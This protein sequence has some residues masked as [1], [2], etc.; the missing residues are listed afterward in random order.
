MESQI[1]FVDNVP[2]DTKPFYSVTFRTIQDAE[3]VMI[4]TTNFYELAMAHPNPQ[5]VQ[6]SQ[7][8]FNLMF[9]RAE[10]RECCVV[11]GDE[12][13]LN[14]DK[15][16]DGIATKDLTATLYTLLCKYM[17]V[18]ADL[19]AP[20]GEEGDDPS[21]EKDE[22]AVGA[23]VV[24]GSQDDYRDEKAPG[25]RY[26][27][28]TTALT[29]LMR[30]RKGS[31]RASTTTVDERRERHN[32]YIGQ[33]MSLPSVHTIIKEELAE[34]KVD[35]PELL[36]TLTNICTLPAPY[37]EILVRLLGL[38]GM[39]GLDGGPPHVSE[40]GYLVVD[41]A[42]KNAYN[43]DMLNVKMDDLPTEKF[44]HMIR[45]P[46][47]V[48]NVVKHASIASNEADHP[49][50][51]NYPDPNGL[52][53]DL[54]CMRRGNVVTASKSNIFYNV[55]AQQEAFN[56]LYHDATHL[57]KDQVPQ[58]DLE[59]IM[60]KNIF[61]NL[62]VDPDSI[63]ARYTVAPVMD[64]LYSNTANH[65]YA[66]YKFHSQRYDKVT[67]DPEA[68]KEIHSA[69]TSVPPQAIGGDRAST[70]LAICATSQGRE[71]IKAVSEALGNGKYKKADAT[72]YEN[73]TDFYQAAVFGKELSK[74]QEDTRSDYSVSPEKVVEFWDK[75]LFKSLLKVF[76]S[77]LG[78]LG[79]I[80]LESSICGV[81]ALTGLMNL[82][83]MGA[84]T[85][86]EQVAA[87]ACHE[88]VSKMGG[89]IV[90]TDGFAGQSVVGGLFRPINPKH[91]KTE[92]MIH[93]FLD[94][95]EVKD[96][97]HEG[98]IPHKRYYRGKPYVHTIGVTVLIDLTVPGMLY[99]P[100]NALKAAD[101]TVV[102]KGQKVLVDD[103]FT[104][105]LYTPGQLSAYKFFMVYMPI[106]VFTTSSY[107]KPLADLEVTHFLSFSP[108][109]VL[110]LMGTY[111]VGWRKDAVLTP[112]IR[113]LTVNKLKN[114]MVAHL[115]A[116]SYLLMDHFTAIPPKPRLI[117]NDLIGYSKALK[118]T[119]AIM[120]KSVGDATAIR[121]YAKR[122]RENGANSAD[123]TPEFY[124]KGA[125]YQPDGKNVLDQGQVKWKG[126]F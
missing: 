81:P 53:N 90:V 114:S 113:T 6:S 16:E 121:E 99:C 87:I 32:E 70:F 74:V 106:T 123:F 1:K 85:K 122:S 21:E 38:Y 45:Q 102:F 111:V 61:V 56:N 76:S 119:H 63:F 54:I 34:L 94:N 62:N 105:M 47:G 79:V 44:K 51:V 23:E 117:Y 67:I 126:D 82:K 5:E 115:V 43:L 3:A 36:S 28:V 100:Q 13:F 8:W 116:K 80:G 25:A 22:G 71:M 49:I 104:P 75:K 65:N 96:A 88:L 86:P 7:H 83:E 59:T 118:F 112:P 17:M 57:Y 93:A 33:M 37:R 20:L 24:D 107:K 2:R 35:S 46:P 41:V 68:G 84:F 29:A 78:F 66:G 124:Y 72:A 55:T 14:I 60:D 26:G 19:I 97:N 12:I 58:E 15:D 91:F 73:Y 101:T 95:G 77:H 89:K 40:G 31:K 69:C 30:I 4:I 27:P 48:N 103:K 10:R 110:C 42:A 120:R 18:Q 125:M 50:A 64:K 92:G 108:G 39:A 9:R 11:H 52:L 98:I 109:P